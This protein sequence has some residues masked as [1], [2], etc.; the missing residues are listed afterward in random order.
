MSSLEGAPKAQYVV[1]RSTERSEACKGTTDTPARCGGHALERIL[2][3]FVGLVG[4]GEYII[5]TVVGGL[6]DVHFV[7]Y[8]VEYALFAEIV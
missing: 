6:G 8:V 5:L 4:Y 1:Q 2:N 7:M 3:V